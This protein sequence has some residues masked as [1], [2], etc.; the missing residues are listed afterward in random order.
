[1][2]NKSYT[3]TEVPQNLTGS[4]ARILTANVF[5]VTGSRKRKRSELAVA[6][7][8]QGIR[9][10]DV[11]T[12]VINTTLYRLMEHLGSN[13]QASYI[14][15]CITSSRVHLSAVFNTSSKARVGPFSKTH[16]LFHHLT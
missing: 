4:N 7:D 13:L 11:R 8:G 14:L 16:V 10:Y 9:I 3:L 6:I 5:S 1:M 15:C 2:F 12:Y